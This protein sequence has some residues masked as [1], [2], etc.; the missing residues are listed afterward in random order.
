MGSGLFLWI[1]S[2]DLQDDPAAGHDGVE[3]GGRPA[4]PVPSPRTCARSCRTM[5]LT[6]EGRREINRQNAEH[7]RDRTLPRE[8]PAQEVRARRGR[9]ACPRSE[10][11]AA[12]GGGRQSS[13]NR[14]TGPTAAWGAVC[15][16]WRSGAPA[17]HASS[18][19]TSQSTGHG[20]PRTGLA[21][22]TDSAGSR[23]AGGQSRRRPSARTG[24]R[25]SG[26]SFAV[27]PLFL[28]KSASRNR[29]TSY[30]RE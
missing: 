30:G 20:G 15:A 3:R 23:V 29:R 26:G 25:V 6:A 27:F 14:L 17:I 28:R 8:Q 13:P 1:E 22:A 10:C 19:G 21:G 12:R 7:A 9:R 24:P 2:A 11:T 16:G 4:R 18:P 5:V